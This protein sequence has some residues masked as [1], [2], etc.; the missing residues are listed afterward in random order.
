[1]KKLVQIISTKRGMLTVHY[2]Y[3]QQEQQQKRHA[4]S[5]MYQF[6]AMDQYS[7]ASPLYHTC[8]VH[9]CRLDASLLCNSQHVRADMKGT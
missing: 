1:M 7:P 4:A 2:T 8:D 9:E 3:A 5:V 6:A